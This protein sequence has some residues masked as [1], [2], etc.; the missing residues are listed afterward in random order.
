M[1]VTEFTTNHGTY[2]VEQIKC[3]LDRKFDAQGCY[4][5]CMRIGPDADFWRAHYARLLVNLATKVSDKSVGNTEWYKNRRNFR[6][7]EV[8]EK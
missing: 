3:S 2:Q 1:K 8:E 6:D 4:D 7:I 5:Y